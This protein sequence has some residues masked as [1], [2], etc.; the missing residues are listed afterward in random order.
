MGQCECENA[1][2]VLSTNSDRARRR[3]LW[4]VLVINTLLFI[5]EFGAGWWGDSSAL[6]ADS[7]DSLY[8]FTGVPH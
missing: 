8:P 4:V 5:G 3:V 1:A 7:L 6:Q 2:T